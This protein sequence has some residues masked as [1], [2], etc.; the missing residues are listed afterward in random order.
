[1]ARRKEINLACGWDVWLPAECHDDAARLAGLELPKSAIRPVPDRAER[2]HNVMPMRK[3]QVQ[4]IEFSVSDGPD[5]LFVAAHDD[6]KAVFGAACDVNDM[7]YSRLGPARY[8]SVRQSA[9]DLPGLG[10][11]R[12]RREIEAGIIAWREETGDYDRVREPSAVA[13]YRVCLLRDGY[14]VPSIVVFPGGAL[15]GG[16]NGQAR[17][18]F[19]GYAR[20]VHRSGQRHFDAFRDALMRR[21]VDAVQAP[22][23][24]VDIPVLPQAQALVDA[25]VELD[26]TL[27]S[28][29]IMH[30]RVNAASGKI[31]AFP[32]RTGSDAG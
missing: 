17:R 21:H 20:L 6:L 10:A 27:L 12:S 24:P 28:R 9:G 13:D 26:A 5:Q 25:G 4:T 7:Y 14:S 2:S 19:C 23:L 18:L 3:F 30:H 31:V 11:S 8:R 22:G 29:H 32:N 16:G 15:L 1:M